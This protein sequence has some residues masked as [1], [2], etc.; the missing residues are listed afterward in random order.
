MNILIIGPPGV[1]KGTQAKLIKTKLGIIHLS[2]GE[3]LRKEIE[4]KT[5]TGIEAKF[6]IDKGEFIPDIT[7]LEIIQR[8]LACSDCSNGY[9]LDGFPRTLAQAI[10]L[11]RII[12]E[13]DQ[14]LDIAISLTADEKI[15]ERRLIDRSLKDN[16]SDDMPSIIKKRQKIYWKQTAPLLKFYKLKG[17]LEQVNGLG[18]INQIT[19]N[20]MNLFK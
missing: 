14:N 12:I 18:E 11:D 15:L 2:T 20:I 13:L 8:R 5:E 10:G 16:R 1:G 7:I 17:I 6:Y 4:N 9:I 19:N 3:I